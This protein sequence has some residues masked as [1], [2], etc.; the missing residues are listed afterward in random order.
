MNG[1]SHSRQLLCL[2]G[3]ALLGGCASNFV[4]SKD[5]TSGGMPFR[6]AVL[7]VKEAEHISHSKNG[8]ACTR[9]PYFEFVPLP[10]GDQYFVKVKPAAFAKT[11]FAMEYH[12]TGALKSLSL[13]TEPAGA[14]E[15]NAALGAATK[16]LAPAGAPD[17][18]EAKRT[19]GLL[20][21]DSGEAILRFVP[22]DKWAREHA[23]TS[24]R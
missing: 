7:F 12:E 13:N 8:G 3:A 16:A 22:F 5:P 21:C 4:V 6:S 23:G 15:L 20:P 19:N 2:V 14:D 9:S 24:G 1:V 11:G 10:A 18:S 17:V